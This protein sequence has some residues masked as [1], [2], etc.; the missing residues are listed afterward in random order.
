MLSISGRAS[1][2]L[3]LHHDWWHSRRQCVASLSW[4][5]RSEGMAVVFCSGPFTV[6]TWSL[7]RVRFCETTWTGLSLTWSLGLRGMVA[8]SWYVGRRVCACDWC[9]RSRT[10]AWAMISER[11][12]SQMGINSTAGRRAESP[13]AK[14][15][16]EGGR[17]SEHDVARIAHPLQIQFS[18]RSFC[19]V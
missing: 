17:E 19:Q 2:E 7:S 12:L 15:A 9:R 11:L 18:F 6:Q 14:S 13:A 10:K 1:W 5:D 8:S 3:C 4:A 16:K